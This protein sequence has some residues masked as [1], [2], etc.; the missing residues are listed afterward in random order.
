MQEII[1]FQ[2]TVQAAITELEKTITIVTIYGWVDKHN[3]CEVI[4]NFPARQLSYEP[5]YVAVK[6][7]DSNEIHKILRDMPNV[8]QY[9]FTVKGVKHD[10]NTKLSCKCL[11][12][13]FYNEQLNAQC[14]IDCGKIMYGY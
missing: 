1:E 12:D 3:L 13:C 10:H 4:H 7:K 6:S 5:Q 14:C 8:E 2:K 9:D 11:G